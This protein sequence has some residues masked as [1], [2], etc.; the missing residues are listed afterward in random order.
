MMDKEAADQ[1]VLALFSPFGQV[2]EVHILRDRA[3]GASKGCAFVKFEEREAAIAAIA[4]LNQVHQ[5]EG[6]P[7][8]LVVKFA[9]SK[10]AKPPASA[11]AMM[12]MMGMMGM[13]MP[14]MGVPGQFPQPAFFPGAWGGGSF[15]QGGFPVRGFVAATGFTPDQTGMR[16]AMYSGY[17]MAGG[18]DAGSKREGPPGANLFVYH[19]PP[20]FTDT[21]LAATFAPFGPILSAKVFID[22]MTGE[23]KGFGFVSYKTQ[24]AAEA[25]ISHMN[26]FQIGTKRLK[27][28]HKKVHERTDERTEDDGPFI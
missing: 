24:R 20:S 18:D 4:A 7:Q 26:G 27:V 5:M 15:P 16:D 19:I 28:Q 2:K 22:R 25:A 21:D 17:G 6:A 23:S 1:D 3:T 12:G 14:G 10:K 13:D 8:P 9:D 11:N